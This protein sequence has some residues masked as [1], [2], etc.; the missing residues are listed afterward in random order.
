MYTV[1]AL[2]ILTTV[3]FVLLDKS[4]WWVFCLVAI[5]F[6]LYY[7][8][9]GYQIVRHDKKEKTDESNSDD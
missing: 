4:Y 9:T 1:P 2:W 6:S 7:A 8:P 3:L 5:L